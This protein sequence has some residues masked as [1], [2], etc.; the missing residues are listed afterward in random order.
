MGASVAVAWI[1]AVLAVGA[2]A[3]MAV[4][5]RARSQR[6][7][8]LDATLAGLQGELEEE[9]QRHERR[10]RSWEERGRELAELRRKLDKAKKRAFDASESTTSLEERISELEKRATSREQEA[11]EARLVAEGLREKLEGERKRAEELTR[12]LAGAGPRVDPQEAASST[13]R[14][15]A[16]E[17]ELAEL[18]EKL[19]AAE[20]EASR[21]RTRER[22]HR[23]LYMVIK[24]ELDAAKDR[25]R[26]LDRQHERRAPSAEAAPMPVEQKAVEP[27][28][29]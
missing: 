22:T 20:R 3:G 1:V 18:T 19:R 21:Y 24:G 14:A 17:A 26:A 7:R 25:L 12:K 13:K 2:A 27:S 4:A 8:E 11:Q 9:R 23:R 6:C 29:V 10:Q 28:E 15:L 5:W 16:A